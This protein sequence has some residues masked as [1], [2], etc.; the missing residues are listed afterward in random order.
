MSV[1]PRAP[2]SATVI[3][4]RGSSTQSHATLWRGLVT[5][6]HSPQPQMVVC[7]V[8]HL[9]NE[10]LWEATS[11]PH[12]VAPQSHSSAPGVGSLEVPPP[13]AHVQEVS[14]LP[15]ARLTL[16]S[17]TK[18]FVNT[19]ALLLRCLLPLCSPALPVSR[20]ASFVFL[21]PS[22]L[23]LSLF[24][25]WNWKEMGDGR[26]KSW[27]STTVLCMQHAVSVFP[28]PA[29]PLSVSLSLSH[30]HNKDTVTYIF[31]VPYT[32]KK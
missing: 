9:N 8:S 27:R 16:L 29:F 31:L 23:S 14:L 24:Y 28:S 20:L 6:H 22:S 4:V 7:A 2:S 32:K 11:P 30:F 19:V 17:R 10:N 12:T 5:A 21:P 18:K 15:A 25:V 1:K 3:R 26:Q 13:S